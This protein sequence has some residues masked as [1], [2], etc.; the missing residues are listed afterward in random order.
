MPLIKIDIEYDG[1]E[2]HGWQYQPDKRTVQGELENALQNIFNTRIR[3]TGAGRTD[4]G[5][6]ALGQVAHF[7]VDAPFDLERLR[8]AIN[9]TTGDDVHI[10]DIQ[11]AADDFHSR[12][13]A[14]SKVYHYNI[15]LT[16]S[17]CRIR[18]HW[19]VKYRL[20]LSRIREALDY[21]IGEHDFKCFSADDHKDNTVCTIFHMN[22]TDEFERIIITVEGN[23]FLRKMVRGIIGFLIDIGR[24]RYSP[25]DILKALDGTCFDNY[26]AP[27]HGLFLMEVRY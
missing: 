2:F 15:T 5:V 9:A 10:K 6:H 13:S 20:D 19:F 3:I 27:P 23:R 18:Y 22:L 4:A 8:S 24:S 1:T 26:F 14:L 7:E 12:F 17:P 16:P 21:F 11:Y 25:Q